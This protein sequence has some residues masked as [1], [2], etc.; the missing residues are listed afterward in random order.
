LPQITYQ[1]IGDSFADDHLTLYSNNSASALKFDQ[2]DYSLL[3]Q[4]FPAGL[5]PG[6]PSDGLTGLTNDFV[7]RGDTRQEIDWPFSLSQF[8]IV[9][10]IMGRVTAY[11][12]SPGGDGQTR[13]YEGV[14]LR[15]TTSFWHI[16][17]SI[18]SDLLD[19]HRIRHVI[20]P[21]I[22][23]FTSGT[24][25]DANKLYDYDPNVDAITDITGAAVAL[26]QH[27]DTMRGGPGRWQSV[28]ILDVNLEGDFYAHKPPPAFLNPVSFRGLF[29]P[30]QPET[31]V[32]RQALNADLTWHIADDTAFLSAVQWNLDT[33][34]TA[35]AEAGL[36]INRGSRLSYYV[37]DAYVQALGSQVFTFDA[38]YNLTAKYVMSLSETLDFGSSRAAVTSISLTRR[39]DMFAFSISAYHDG[40]NNISGF[41]INFFPTGQPGFSM[42][43]G[44]NQ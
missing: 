12:N 9:P 8:K 25:V 23:L 41:N 22:N 15:M 20:Q 10:Y 7:Y 3:R 24:S 38:N 42:P 1:R 35:I 29:Y 31:S 36:A 28:D 19:L 44:V 30:S 33:H 6:L 13:L 43:W 4:G 21:E 37:G 16:D 26:H 14:G 18:D 32:A 34:E 11:S 39:F 40:I 27:W 5:S 2:S 17:D